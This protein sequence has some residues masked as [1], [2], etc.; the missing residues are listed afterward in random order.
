MNQIWYTIFSQG[1]KSWIKPC[2]VWCT[3]LQT[4][5]V[6]LP[7][8]LQVCCSGLICPAIAQSFTAQARASMCITATWQLVPM[9]LF[10]AHGGGLLW[11]QLFCVRACAKQLQLPS[12]GRHVRH[13]TQWRV[14]VLSPM[15]AGFTHHVSLYGLRP[16]CWV[17]GLQ[18]VW[19]TFVHPYDHVS[20]S[21][22]VSLG[23]LCLFMGH[24]PASYRVGYGSKCRTCW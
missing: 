12:T 13:T 6:G 4:A 14:G 8:K 5:P 17:Y 20:L 22:C 10:P 1:L 23:S 24:A 3:V 15:L 18:Q 16:T 9:A 19:V 2:K 21:D 7:E 11:L